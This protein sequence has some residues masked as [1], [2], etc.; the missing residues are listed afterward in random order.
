M[1]W[2]KELKKESK[3]ITLEE[4]IIELINLNS[5]KV[6]IWYDKYY[7]S[8]SWWK[9][10]FDDCWTIFIDTKTWEELKWCVLFD[11]VI[12]RDCRD[13]EDWIWSDNIKMQLR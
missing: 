13:F 9:T 10:Y 12:Y 4:R 7:S 3:D 11:N 2:N 8:V 5:T 1:F 6:G